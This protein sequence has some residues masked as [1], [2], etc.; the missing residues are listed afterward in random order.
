MKKSWK[1]FLVTALLCVCAACLFACV[2]NTSITVTVKFNIEGAQDV[3]LTVN[4]DETVYG[5]LADV[6]LPACGYQFDGWFDSDG[7]QINAYTQFSSDATVYAQWSAAYSM[8][9]YLQTDDGYAVD[10]SLTFTGY[11]KVGSTVEITRKQIAGY[12]VDESNVNNVKSVTLGQGDAVLKLYYTRQTVT[13]SFDKNLPSATGTMSDVAGLFGSLEVLPSNQF[14]SPTGC[15]FVGWNTAADGSG[16]SYEDGKQITLSNDMTLYAQ[17]LNSYREIIYCEQPDGTFTIATTLLKTGLVG[18]T[19]LSQKNP[20]NNEA[21]YEFDGT[22]GVTGG[23]LT[24][25]EDENDA[26]K[27][28]LK[29]YFKYKTYTVTYGDD[30]LQVKVKYGKTLT[31]RTPQDNTVVSYCT[32]QTGNG[33]EYAFGQEITVTEDLTLYPVIIDIYADN[34]GSGDT[35]SIRRHMTGLGSAVL[36]RGGTNYQGFVNADSNAVYFD[37]TVGSDEIHGKLLKDNKFIYRNEDEVGKYVY[38]DYLD[39]TGEGVY[40][41]YVFA[42]D[43]YGIGAFAV[44][45]ADGTGR[46]A[47][48]YCEYAVDANGDYCMQYYLPSE[49]EKIYEDNF[50]LIRDKQQIDTGSEK[51]S[52]DGFFKLRGT[53]YGSYVL[54]YNRDLQNNGLVLD[55]YGGGEMI[56]FDGD[57]NKTNSVKGVYYA[58]DNYTDEAPE[59][60]FAP[61]DATIDPVYFILSVI[62]D[63]DDPYYVFMVRREEIGT[64]RQS[65]GGGY[66]ELYLDGYGMGLLTAS[67]SDGGRYAYYSVLANGADGYTIVL[68]FA[69]DIG[70][71]MQVSL[72]K[73]NGVY[74][75]LGEFV[76]D[77]NGVLTEYIGESSVI[78]I[79][80]GVTEIADKVFYG[81]NITALTLPSTLVKIGSKA[82]QN[83]ASSTG[84]SVLTTIYINAETPPTLSK[85]KD[86]DGNIEDGDPNPFRWL[87]QNAKIF[88]PDGCEEAYRTAETWVKYV[89]NIT[90][91]A[92]QNN[93]P[94]FEV[95]GDGVL[96]SYNNKDANPSN[97]AITLPEEVTAIADGVFAGLEYIVSVNLNNAVTIGN[98]AFYGCVG[99]TQITF[100]ADMVSIGDEAFYQCVGLTKLNLGNVQTI[101]DSAF[102]RCFNLA[103]V[104]VGSRITSIGSMAFA[105]CSVN[106]DDNGSIASFNDFVLTLSAATA[107]NMGGNVFHE[108]QPRIYVTSFDVGVG[109]TDNI[110]WTLYATALRVKN[111]GEDTA[112]YAKTNMGDVL[113]LGDRADFGDGSYVGLYKFDGGYLY[114]TWFNRDI[115][116][117]KLNVVEQRAELNADGEWVGLE[118]ADNSYYFVPQG[119]T[120]L[121]SNGEQ[122]LKV[123]Y[124]SSEAEFNGQP[125]TMQVVNYRMRFDLDGYRYVPTLYNDG[126]F[127][128]T[129]TFITVENTYTAEDGSTI[130]I[131][132]GDRYITA[133]GLLKNVGGLEL[134]CET[135][136]WYLTR[137]NDSVYTWT[138]SWLN[139]RYAITAAVSGETFTYTFAK[140]ATIEA[141]R[142]SFGDTATATVS[143]QTGEITGILMSF[144]TAN[145]YTACSTTYF[146]AQPDGTYLVTVAGDDNEDGTP[147]EFNGTY[148]LTMNKADKTFTLIKQA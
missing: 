143:Q 30:N 37:V 47:N 60:V 142:N 32:S 72:D 21:F 147:C 84:Q 91:R 136:S 56:T 48:F 96:L 49:P 116:T 113:T 105:A 125:V 20:P 134:K 137:Q 41:Y 138:V 103:R 86:N 40:P 71:K 15:L 70:G 61:Q 102:N 22:Q 58:S 39:H 46:I 115:Y 126:M 92:E 79:P 28:V 19:V 38:F 87:Q 130:T 43:G 26:P 9:Y 25:A 144:K 1:L 127:S 67:E 57:G 8:Q 4:P 13:V 120:V 110:T 101:G 124:G 122:T 5:K 109:Y 17:W 35:V 54:L 146:A 140:S 133:N 18:S 100:N 74:S 81:K 45:L 12:S 93:K 128:V 95:N 75:T 44:P 50:V 16:E 118:L 94:L 77:D 123:T 27:L 33:R 99:L 121:F 132:L 42:L 29:T 88:V 24:D 90:S 112:L 98:Q 3:T 68:E 135:W 59:Y 6:Q 62:G 7:K 73:V 131:R 69:D 89:D 104:T 53:E 11:G 64:Y 66:P 111:A 36:N 65:A 63:A 119:H 141:Y 34:N 106:L 85:Q 2:E 80:E 78:V 97:V 145:G 114:V 148:V 14:Q 55:G 139:D 10:N 52:I 83:S 76:I 129:K 107:P 117:N 108:A 23:L 31:V 82:F 51:I